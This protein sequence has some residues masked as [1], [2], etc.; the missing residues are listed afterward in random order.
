MKCALAAVG[1]RSEDIGYNKA[2]LAETLRKCAGRADVVLFGESFLQGFYGANFVVEHD[3]NVA[4]SRTDAV[5]Q[6]IAGMAREYAIAVSF[7]FLEQD[8]DAFFSAQMTFDSRG[9]VLDLYRRVSPGWK[10]HDAGEQYREGSGFHTFSFLGKSVAV[11]LC[12]DLWY[13]ENM[14]ALKGLK[15][16]VVWWPV[17]TDF[18]DAQWNETIK[19]EYAE[20]AGKLNAPVLYVNSVCL[21]P[22]DEGQ[23]AKGGAALFDHGQIKKELPAGEEGILIVEVP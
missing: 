2:V 7:G 8:G 17:Y 5:M 19:L 4:V 23:L 15:P 3:R 18:H 12:G 6:E 9:R 10:E 14:D 22:S 11:G 20:Q 1:F 21:F 13:E 16:D